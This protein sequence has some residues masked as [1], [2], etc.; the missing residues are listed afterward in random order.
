MSEIDTLVFCDEDFVGKL[1]KVDG[2]FDLD[3]MITGETPESGY[4]G[5]CELVMGAAGIA[6]IVF[7]GI[8]NSTTNQLV[9]AFMCRFS[10]EF[11]DNNAVAIVLKPTHGG[12]HATARK[13]IVRPVRDGIGADTGSGTGSAQIKTDKPAADV[14]FYKGTG[15]SGWDP[16]FPVVGDAI[17]VRSWLP[18]V[19]S[20]APPESAWSVEVALPIAPG[21]GD[22]L[23]G[24]TLSDDF[25]FY[26]SVAKIMPVSG[27]AI[28][29]Q[30]WFPSSSAQPSNILETWAPA[31]ADYGHGIIPHQR[32]QQLPPNIYPGVG[33][34]GGWMGIG[35]RPSDAAAGSPVSSTIKGKN[36]PAG[37]PD[38][39]IVAKLRNNGATPADDITCE[40]RFHRYGLGPADPL[41]WNAP[42]GLD[43]NPSPNRE[44][45]SPEPPVNVGAGETNKEI[46][47]LWPITDPSLAAVASSDTCMWAQLTARTPVNFFQSS[48]RR[49]MT[50][51]NL[52]ETEGEA[53]VSGEGYEEPPEGAADHDFIIET[54]CRRVVVQELVE[55]T[56]YIDPALLPIVARSLAG[57]KQGLAE[58]GI[59]MLAVSGNGPSYKDSVI[60]VWQNFG[61]RVTADTIT[62]GGTTYPLVDNGSGTFGS[63][64]H[65][66]GVQDNFGWTFEGDGMVRYAP[67]VYGI[68][69][70]HKGETVI[71]FRLV[72][73]REAPR[74][75]DSI[76]LPPGRFT[77]PKPRDGSGPVKPGGSGPRG[78]LP[79][80]AA[81]FAIL[82]AIFALVKSG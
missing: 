29:T 13:I 46:T 11:A 21:A 8:R 49:N 77:P 74:G 44:G 59:K 25:G 33:F 43:P 68:K 35:C 82:A 27:A 36:A 45:P 81:I 17:K 18:V 70:P 14:D 76:K 41:L 47:A 30:Y 51:V 66:T 12:S 1:P 80:G 23:D 58:G 53:V 75:D 61:Y 72:A 37:T 22:L 67:G 7:R 3:Y 73:D 78:C 64:A 65:H 28:A 2:F 54:F 34:D 6:P 31:V 55:K 42:A 48:I 19:P 71:K 24:I 52:S 10:R 38:N 63:V 9:L 20:G 32:G 62:I 56:E 16:Y 60:Y 79:V 40:F 57:T 50:F 15:A 26:F 39:R 5:G 69:V 4:L